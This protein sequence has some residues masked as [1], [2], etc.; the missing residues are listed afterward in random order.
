MLR[1][2][3]LRRKGWD[4]RVCGS[5]GRAWS[6]LLS[7]QYYRVDRMRKQLQAGLYLSGDPSSHFCSIVLDVPWWLGVAVP[8]WHLSFR[9][10]PSHPRVSSNS[11]VALIDAWIFLIFHVGYKSLLTVLILSK[12]DLQLMN[13]KSPKPSLKIRGGGRILRGKKEQ[14]DITHSSFLFSCNSVIEFRNQTETEFSKWLQDDIE[15]RW[16][17]KCKSEKDWCNQ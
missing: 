17:G 13:V 7:V 16:R 1:S 5:L 6:N 15:W 10:S 14:E 2:Y 11:I 12:F 8:Q 4:A 9:L 3:A